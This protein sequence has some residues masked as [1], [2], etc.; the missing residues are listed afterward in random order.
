[1][2]KIKAITKYVFKGEEFNSLTEIKEVIHNIIGLEVLDKIN[3]T[4][5][6]AKH[7]DYEKLLNLLCS[8]EVRNVLLESLNVKFDRYID[9]DET[10][11]INVLDI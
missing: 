4:C 10:E 3:K 1:M 9:E 11:T 5:P 6:L 7:R 8:K 2:P